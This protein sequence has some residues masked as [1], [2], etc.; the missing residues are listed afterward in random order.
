MTSHPSDPDKPSQ[1]PP[2]SPTERDLAERD[3]YTARVSASVAS[4]RDSAK[5]WRNGLTG[6]V[7]LIITGIVVQGHQAITE[8]DT[9]WR[10][11]ISSFVTV[12]LAMVVAGLWIA[13]NAEIMAGSTNLT[14]ADVRAKYS[15]FEAY[16]ITLAVRVTRKT[17][18]S[19]RI[20]GSGFTLLLIGILL[21]WW[22]PYAK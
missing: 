13:F 14:L 16:E 5:N 20:A 9:N 15:T 8:L 2:R 22:A 4:A 1:Q 6:F 10:A 21:T 11:I 18:Q 3:A 19:T 7:T 12:G 17:Y